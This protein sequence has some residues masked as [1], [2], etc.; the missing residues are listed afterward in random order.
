[1]Y[2]YFYEGYLLYNFIN[3]EDL[4]MKQKNCL[5]TFNSKNDPSSVR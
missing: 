3:Y 1:M 2:C 5:I 4:N